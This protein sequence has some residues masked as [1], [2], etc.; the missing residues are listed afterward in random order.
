MT[1]LSRLSV[2]AYARLTPEQRR[3]VDE[4]RYEDPDSARR[5]ELK[6]ILGWRRTVEETIAYA[7]KLVDGG[8]ALS[9]AAIRLDVDPDY[10]WRL[11]E[12]VPDIPNRSRNPS[13]HPE[14]P[15]LT[16]KGKGAG[17]PPAPE[18]PWPVYDSDPFAYDFGTAL[19][20]A[21]E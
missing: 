1:R 6:T 3:A 2:R 11:L 7:R 13:T 4:L 12:K 9:A 19:R 16:D 14:N 10:L 21:R 8:M 15:G 18:R 17:L 5:G 20:S